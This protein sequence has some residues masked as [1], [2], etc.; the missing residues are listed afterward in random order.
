MTAEGE[1]I[2]STRRLFCKSLIPAVQQPAYAHRTERPSLFPVLRLYISKNLNIN[3]SG[4]AT[5]TQ[6]II[7]MTT[8][9]RDPS[10]TSTESLRTTRL[11]FQVSELHPLRR[12]MPVL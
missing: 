2:T 12:G 4:I 1:L 3:I 11:G 6:R 9:D 5:V 8:W 10:V 7:Q